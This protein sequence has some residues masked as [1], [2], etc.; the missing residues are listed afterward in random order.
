MSHRCRWWI[1]TSQ[2]TGR[3]SRLAC[4][5]IST[6]PA[7]DS[8]HTWTRARVA[9]TSSRI[10]PRA[11]VSANGDAGQPESRRNL[12]VV[13]HAVLRKP[14]IFRA[15][16]YRVSK[17]GRILQRAPQQLRVAQRHVAL[18]KRDTTGLAELGH[19]GERLAPQLYRQRSQR[20]DARAGKRL[21]APT[22]SEEHT[23]ELQSPMYL[24]CRLLLEKK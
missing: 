12:A 6:A 3:P 11:M 24:V 1:A 8:R 16:P 13:R 4:R 21:G 22:R 7:V 14:G 9:R 10:V 17:R 19:L 2:L 15:Q 23:S 18:R 5:I 20:I